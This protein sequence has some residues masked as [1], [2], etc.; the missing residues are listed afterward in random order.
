V[1][2][3]FITTIQAAI[4]QQNILQQQPRPTQPTN[5]RHGEMPNAT[6]MIN[7]GNPYLN[8]AYSNIPNT[9][10]S[11]MRMMPGMQGSMPQR[12]MPPP[13]MLNNNGIRQ[14]PPGNPMV[15]GGMS[16]PN[17]NYTPRPNPPGGPVV[18]PNYPNQ[19]DGQ[20]QASARNNVY[21]I[22][23]INHLQK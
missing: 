23:E 12:G 2:N 5:M 18:M 4:K 15:P 9:A 19:G 14:Q 7:R 10:H 20:N 1:D 11:N 8:P 22:N 6:G 16:Q 3:S 13:G 17:R 21:R